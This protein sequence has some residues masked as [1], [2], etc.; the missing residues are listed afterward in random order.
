MRLSLLPA[1]SGRTGLC[2]F[3]ALWLAGLFLQQSPAEA[4]IKQV[5]RISIINELGPASPAT[6]LINGQIR[7][8]LELSP[9]PVEL[10][11]EFLETTLFPDPARQKEFREWVPYKYRDRKPEVI[12]T[13]GSSPTRFLTQS[14]EKFFAQTPVVFCI[15]REE[16]AGPP[17]LDA[18][19]TGV[20]ESLRR[21]GLDESDLPPGSTVQFRELSLRERGKTIWISVL[22]T[23]LSLAALAV[24]LQY[25][26]SQLRVA[27]D[28]QLQLSG[29]LINAQEKERSRLAAELHDDFSQRVALLVYGLGDAVDH[30]RASPDAVREKLEALLESTK[31]LGDDLH[32]V[33]H[34]LHS[35]T[36]ESL[37]LVEGLA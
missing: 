27:R 20:V 16:W 19:F 34:R 31:E 8:R 13:V 6:A 35:S 23:I 1:N 15:N 3:A 9:Y 14:H 30:L 37:G 22:V 7:A 17:Q 18:F 10:C 21:W 5:R 32:T 33:S 24:Y 12:I 4:H 25:S 11:S 2:G 29:L 36:L 28:A 26:R